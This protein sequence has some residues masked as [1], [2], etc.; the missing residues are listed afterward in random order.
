MELVLY[1]AASEAP[2]L[3]LM[4][5]RTEDPEEAAGK[6]NVAYV[7]FYS[8]RAGIPPKAAPNHFRF[9][10]VKVGLFHRMV[11]LLRV[12]A[13]EL[14]DRHVVVHIGWPL[15][16]WLDRLAIGVMV[17]NL[18]RLPR[19]FPQFEFLIQYTR[20]TAHPGFSPGKS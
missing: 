14:G 18:M 19:L 12:V 17:F 15:S 8:P 4:F 16:S 2:E 9:P 7:T 13:Y 5:R 6:D 1:L 20:R 3:H 11:S 10:M